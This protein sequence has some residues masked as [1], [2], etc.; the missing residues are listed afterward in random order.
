[1]SWPLA[2]GHVP[3]I[4]VT[5]AIRSVSIFLTSAP[6]QCEYT[7]YPD[8]YSL[9]LIISTCHTHVHS[10]KLDCLQDVAAY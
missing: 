9:T 1:M 8:T 6:Q 5:L 2:V 3:L 7:V 10:R 4:S